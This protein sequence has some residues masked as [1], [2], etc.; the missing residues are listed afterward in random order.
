MRYIFFWLLFTASGNALV[1]Q[2]AIQGTLV[3]GENVPLAFGKVKVLNENRGAIANEDG[4][5]S[6]NDVS[7]GDS[8]KISHY[9]VSSRVVSVA[10]FLEND[11][12]FLDE[13]FQEID[14]VEVQGTQGALLELFDIAR[15]KISKSQPIDSK[16]YFSLESSA[17]GTPVELIEAY[18]QGKTRGGRIEELELK[19][20]RVGMSAMDNQYFVSLSTT[21]ILQSYNLH[22]ATRSNFPESPM[23]LSLRKIKRLFHYRV[24]A[25]QDGILTIVFTPKK[26]VNRAALFPTTVYLHKPT[27]EI[28][29]IEFKKPNLTTHPFTEIN[30][31]DT[32]KRLDYLAAYT[33][34]NTTHRLER[35]E[36]NYQMKYK[37]SNGIRNISSN[38]VL[39]FHDTASD[40]TLPVYSASTNL[41]S[42]YDKIVSQPYNAFFW[43]TNEAISPSDKKLLY[44]KYFERHGVLL[45]FNELSAINPKVF[46]NKLVP[47]SEN[48]IQLYD[49]NDVNSYKVAAAE[50]NEYH[51]RS[52]LSE[53]YELQAFIYL[54]RNEAND[55]THFKVETLIN[56]DESFYYLK[57]TPYT[58]CF[59][60][61]YF[62]LVEI[63][64]RKLAAL[65]NEQQS[66][67]ESWIRLYQKNQTELD[68]ILKNYLKTVERGTNLEVLNQ[69]IDLVKEELGIDNAFLIQNEEVWQQLDSIDYIPD[70]IIQRYNY[71]S[72]L[73]KIDK[74]AEAL[75]VLL[76]TEAMGDKHPWLLYN[77][78]LCYWKL[79]EI[80]MA[81]KYF[82]QSAT[83][84]EPLETEILEL[85]SE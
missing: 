54:D 65:V 69:Y 19:N 4:R 68:G 71:G 74:Y 6:L 38:A 32:I 40:F 82:Q 62:D 51:N 2:E 73:L 46:A 28:L 41:Y 26:A 80:K 43:N 30:P 7:P 70:P 3:S 27:R 76:E 5:F 60:N 52:V 79:D 17:D 14:A 35:I 78:G 22:K 16:G 12:L 15:D 72:A 81:C 61:L 85:C 36:L 58:V 56:L 39:L 23:M 84:G 57:R 42:D 48:R 31:Q 24:T 13:R 25:I 10:Y 67:P 9:S 1:A 83:L 37:G 53:L 45:N 20:G 75:E 50:R 63:Q 66:D 77:I 34:E 29:R 8:L 21:Q 55:S 11:T 49:M 44:K 47:W 59:V 33:F 18:Y 64:R